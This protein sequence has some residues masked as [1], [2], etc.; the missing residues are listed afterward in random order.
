MLGNMM[1]DQLLISG[2]LEHAI[3]NNS[4]TEVVSN[5]IEGGLHRYTI[6]E[7]AKRSKQL[8][9]ALASMGIKK[10]DIIGTVAVNGYRH[11]ELYFGVSGIGAVLHTLNPRLFPEHVEYIINH[12]EDKYIF[13]D[14][15][16]LPIIE[17]VFEKLKTVK[18]V[19][20]LAAKNDMPESK[21]KN[22][23][24][25]EELISKESTEINWPEF[26]EHT[27]SSLCY[28]SGTTG[29]PK[30]ALYSHR[31]TIVHAWFSSAGNGF[32]MTPSSIVLP[33]VPMFHVNAWGLPYA[34]FMFGAKLVLPG[35]FTDGESITNLIQS[36]DVKQLVGVPT[37]WLDLLNY[38]EKNNITLDTIETV[39]VGGA[40][41]PKSMIKAFQEKHNAFMNHGWGMTEMSPVGTMNAYKPEMDEMNIEDRYEL[42]TSQGKSIYGCSIKIIDENGKTLP[43]DGKTYGRLMV[44]GPGVI[45]RYY[46]AEQS[47]LEDG[48][49]DT[50]D[51]STITDDGY[52]KIVDRSKDVIKSGGE[53]IS[54]IDL[55]NTA[56]GHPG[57]AEAC[58][59]GVLHPKWDERPLLF[60]V[61]N[62][63]EDCDKDSIISYLADKI[64]KWWLPDDVIFVEELPHGATG[65]LVKT[66][67]RDEYKN[68]LIDSN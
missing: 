53:W 13:V 28:T 21:I 49:F 38:T 61:K 7:S 12:A 50:G 27:A 35:P 23:I 37:V 59:I 24:C 57:V 42:Q 11:L 31:S 62:G 30:G 68:H 8:A 5:T 15:P 18:G 51:V 25:Y 67:L 56:V 1:K 45:E 34:A 32:N 39:L 43:N 40:A 44:K 36:E 60:I 22:L 46:K 54:S 10:G 52:M 19:V 48:W 26:D 65:K 16:F 47:A 58:V 20:V 29:N 63:I 41:A 4:K 17:G 33:V 9:N 2:I 64:A 14:V 66:G 55:E 3:K 6:L